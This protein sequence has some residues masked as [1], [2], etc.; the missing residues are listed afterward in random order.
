[1]TLPGSDYFY[2]DINISQKGN[3]RYIK[4]TQKMGSFGDGELEKISHA[5]NG[6][7]TVGQYPQHIFIVPW[8]DR[9]WHFP[10]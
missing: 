1:M 5:P 2:S 8:P 3:R 7:L 9:S 6:S 10:I 4:R